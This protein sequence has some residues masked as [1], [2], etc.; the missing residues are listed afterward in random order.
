MLLWKKKSY[1]FLYQELRKSL[2]TNFDIL[3]EK[4]DLSPLGR[5]F[6]HT[7]TLKINIK[8]KVPQEYETVANAQNLERSTFPLTYIYK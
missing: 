7:V 6:Q 1:Q 2:S 5:T 3:F 8:L 4:K